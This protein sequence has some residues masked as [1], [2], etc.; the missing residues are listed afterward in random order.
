MRTNKYDGTSIITKK[1]PKDVGEGLRQIAT[2]AVA[3]YKFDGVAII[4]LK[5]KGIETHYRSESVAK[6]K[7]SLLMTTLVRKLAVMFDDEYI[8]SDMTVREFVQKAVY[9]A[10]TN[11]HEAKNI[12][13]KNGL[14][15]GMPG[16]DKSTTG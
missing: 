8:N 9:E 13:Y 5:T 14:A 2:C 16:S 10:G 11:T 6:D 7:H 4:G 15:P 1:P 3:A 12:L